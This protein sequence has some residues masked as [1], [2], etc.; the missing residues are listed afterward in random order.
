MRNFFFLC[1]RSPVI[2]GGL[3]AIDKNWF[4]ELGKYDMNMDVWGG[5]NLGNVN[6]ICGR[7]Q[8]KRIVY[9][10]IGNIVFLV[11]YMEI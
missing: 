1:F 8:L 11:I 2:A 9:L 4:S 5:E 3:F 6:L 10:S 7:F